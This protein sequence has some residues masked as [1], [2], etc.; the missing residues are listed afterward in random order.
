MLAA[1][2]RADP[3]A[4]THGSPRPHPRQTRV[5]G[6]MYE[7]LRQ[8]LNP[9]LGRTKGAC[10]PLTL[11]RLGVHGDGGSRT[12]NRPGASGLLCHL[13]FIPRGLELMRTDGV[14][15]SQREASRLQRDEL[16]GCSASAR[17]RGDRP[18]SNRYREDHGAAR[19]CE[20]K[21][22]RSISPRMLA[23]A[24]RADPEAGNRR[25][26]VT[27]SLTNPSRAGC[28]KDEG[29]TDRIRTGTARITTSDAAV[30]PQSPWKRGRPG[31]NRRPLA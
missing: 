6:L 26:P 9:H 11:R 8:E 15:P 19:C 4:G 24:L 7:S 17:R 16:T 23:A 1:A 5:S 14:E 21:A 30:T 27:P 29:A 3:E 12:R 2:L 31:S 20:G 13:S 18:D 25:F 10:L 22:Y 28:S